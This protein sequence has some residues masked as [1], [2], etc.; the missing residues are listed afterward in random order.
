MDT[1]P[2]TYN[3]IGDYNL[4]PLKQWFSTGGNVALWLTGIV[5]KVLLESG[6]RAEILLYILQ[7][8][9]LTR[10]NNL[11]PN[12]RSAAVENPALK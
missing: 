12:V 8:T 9:E 2:A 10:N 5:W 6:Q 11:V 1:H 4:I 7:C 3:F